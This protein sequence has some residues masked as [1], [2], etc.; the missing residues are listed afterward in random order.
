MK[1]MV[2]TWLD[3][4][5]SVVRAIHWSRV[6]MFGLR[7]LLPAPFDLEERHGIALQREQLPLYGVLEQEMQERFGVQFRLLAG[8]AR[9][10]TGDGLAGDE[11]ALGDAV[12][13]NAVGG[14][15]RVEPVDPVLESEDVGSQ[16]LYTPLAPLG[17][18]PFQKGFVGG[19]GVRPELGVLFVA[20]ALETIA[21]SRDFDA[22]ETLVDF[23]EALVGLFAGGGFGFEFDVVP[24]VWTSVCLRPCSGRPRHRGHDCGI[25][26]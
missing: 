8:W 7:T 2:R 5:G 18:H 15:E 17:A 21:E 20:L 6:M 10:L 22:G 16:V 13:D 3:S 25:Y 14:A 23:L 19:D 26:R 9:L 4:S 1:I 12:G 24:R 11:L